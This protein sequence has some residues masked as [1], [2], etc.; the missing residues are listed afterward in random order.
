MGIQNKIVIIGAGFAGLRLAQDLENTNFDVLLID[1]NNYHQFQPLMYQ[2]ATARLEPASIS[3]PLRKVFQHSK[4]VRIRIADVLSVDTQS[5]KLRT[6]IAD[7][8]YDH[9]IIAFGC[10]TNYF[11]NAEIDD[12]RKEFET[13]T[14]KD[15]RP[16]FQQWYLRGG[17]PSIEIR[18]D[19]NDTTKLLG[20]YIEQKQNAEVGLYKFPLKFKVTQ[21]QQTKFFNF[22]I[23]KR[24]ESFFVQKFDESS[25]SFPNVIVDPEAVFIGEI[26]DNRPFFNH[27]LTY[28]T[29]GSYVEKIRSL[30]ALSGMQKQ[31]D[32]ARF[33]ILSAI[34]DPDED[35]R[36][37]ALQWV[38]WSNAD[39]YSKT[40][41]ILIYQT[42]N[43]ASAAVRAEATKILGDKKDP[44]LL[45]YFIELTNDS[46]Y[47]VAGNALEAVYK[48]LPDEGFRLA[49]KL[50]KDVRGK[51][52]EQVCHIYGQMG[53][54]FS[55]NFFK[56]NLMKFH[57]GNRVK[58]IEKYT[59]LLLKLNSSAKSM[60]LLNYSS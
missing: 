48:I 40:K 9:L 34:N 44:L 31:L 13:V 25:N 42:K 15:L 53:D 51:L 30:S 57:K 28:N 7:F 45:N 33:T 3:F 60:R 55:L 54:Q 43:D 14:G 46:S 22:E 21:G 26:K 24:K 38:D 4:N 29:A 36:L 8:E 10:T 27:I 50:D 17:H 41:D 16:F 58:L 20:V 37:R 39:S 6:S 5:K 19:Y 11:G 18:Y 56:E 52:F 49:A 32:T 23:S 35:I 1:K 59:L 12:L 2:V 47:S